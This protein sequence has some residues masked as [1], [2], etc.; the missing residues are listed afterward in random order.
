MQLDDL[1][2]MKAVG[3]SVISPDGSR[4]VFELKRF[5]LK[6]NRNYINLMIV[7]TAGGKPRHLTRGNHVDQLP[8]WSPDG[9]RI[10]FVSD[11]DKG[12]TL[13]TMDMAG[14]EPTR[15][16]E[17]DGFVSDFAWSP[18]GRRI[19]YAYKPMN[20]R[21]RLERDGKS[22]EI[23][24]GPQYKHI[25]RL[26]HKL[27]GA[28][29]W[30]GR[31]NHIYIINVA[32]GKAKQL[33]RGDYDDN[34]PRFSPD[35][36]RV[37]F[38]SNRVENPDMNTENADLYVVPASGGPMRKLTQMQ[39]MVAAHAWSPDGSTIAYIGDPA[40]PGQW[41]NHLESVWLVDSRG[42]KP[43]RLTRDVDN[44]C[45][46]STLGDVVDFCFNMSPPIWSADG[47]RLYFLIS[48]SGATRLYSRSI[49]RAD[50]R[51]EVGGDLNV[52]SVRRTA[53]EGPI[54][55]SIGTATNSGDVYVYDP[56]TREAPQRLTQVNEALFK[57]V[58]VAEPERFQVKSGNA[59]IEGWAL[60]PPGF[61]STRKYPAILQ[62]HGGP[63]AQYGYGFF[64]EMQ[65][66]AARGFVVA[67]GNPRG[68]TGHGLDFSRCI[69][70]D[71]GNLD[72]KDV[73]RLADWLSGRRYVDSKRVGVT[74]GSYGG[75]MTNML[76][77][78]SQ[79]FKAA[80][81]QRC[82]SNFESMFGTSDFGHAL[83]QEFGGYPWQKRDTYLRQ[84]PLT[85]AS[86]VTTPLLIIHSEED[87]RC[88]IE[89]AEQMFT[90]LKALGREVELV[91]FEGE[92]HGLS[93]GG[94]PQNRAERL[95]RMLDWFEK[96][97]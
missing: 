77:G 81:T 82:V 84:S 90:T 5:D 33:T 18:N 40:K 80:V 36:K 50:T 69:H 78:R 76:V 6:T 96:R 70:A 86:K 71:W 56:A 74:G 59:T 10:A 57:R 31:Y 85:Y 13:W 34:E 49:R 63:R 46:N 8:R 11:R 29:W 28:G 45:Y 32:G 62:I 54:A 20:E 7:D 15:L 2:R 41:W 47:K 88:P 83:G 91:R 42:G 12:A 58:D 51:L 16:T 19:A 35:G 23:K 39:G 48:E 66:M 93:R 3:Q 9:K 89:Q 79:R 43:R 25:T 65:L 61:K 95:R 94:R 60:K 64:H 14:G 26:F 21:Q 73:N 1:F 72:Y 68:S 38:V 97:L 75:F 27:D 17:P 52:G 55:L 53:N 44:E 4:V 30:N 24:R 22:D 67:Y 92:S 87:H 37:S